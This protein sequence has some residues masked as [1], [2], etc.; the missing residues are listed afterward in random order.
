MKEIFT[1]ES[2]SRLERLLIH[3]L[4]RALGISCSISVSQA[5]SRRNIES[6][7]SC[8]SSRGCLGPKASTHHK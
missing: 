6:Q 1:K 3:K 2:G 5:G 8:A 4:Q 7:E